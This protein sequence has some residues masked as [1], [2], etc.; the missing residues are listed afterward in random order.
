[1]STKNETKNETKNDKKDGLLGYLEVRLISLEHIPLPIKQIA[2]N[3]V[4]LGVNI[5]VGNTKRRTAS[6]VYIQNKETT[7]DF[8]CNVRIGVRLRDID[9]I[10]D[11]RVVLTLFCVPKNE[12]VEEQKDS[13]ENEQSKDNPAKYLVAAR[14]LPFMHLRE[15]GHRIKR[16]LVVHDK[17]HHINAYGDSDDDEDI[18]F[19]QHDAHAQQLP[20]LRLSLSWFPR[21]DLETLE[22]MLYAHIYAHEYRRY[23]L[24]EIQWQTGH[25]EGKPQSL[26]EAF[27]VK[28]KDE[29][30]K[31]VYNYVAESAKRFTGNLTFSRWNM[32]RLP[33]RCS[34]VHKDGYLKETR[35]GNVGSNIFKL[36]QR[37]TI[38]TVTDDMIN[39]ADRNNDGG[40]GYP[41]PKEEERIK[42]SPLAVTS[43]ILRALFVQVDANSDGELSKAEWLTAV[44]KNSRVRDLLDNPG[45]PKSLRQLLNP[46]KYRGALLLMDTNKDGLIS[47]EELLDFGLK[48]AK[49]QVQVAR[50]NARLRAEARSK[51]PQTPGI[52]VADQIGTLSPE[53]EAAN[54][55]K[56]LALKAKEAEDNSDDDDDEEIEDVEPAVFQ[57]LHDT[58]PQFTRYAEVFLTYGVAS[59]KRILKLTENEIKKM[60]VKNRD[61]KPLMKGVQRLKNEVLP[62][63]F[64]MNF[65]NRNLFCD[66]ASSKLFQDELQVLEH[67]ILLSAREALLK[68]RAEAQKFSEGKGDWG[69]NEDLLLTPIC[70]TPCI[71]L[72][73]ERHCHFDISASGL[74][75]P[76]GL[77]GNGFS[78]ASVKSVLR[79][80]SRIEN[81]TPSQI[82]T[83]V[84][85]SMDPTQLLWNRLKAPDSEDRRGRYTIEQI[86]QLLQTA[87]TCFR[88]A[89]LAAEKRN[90]GCNGKKLERSNVV[91]IH[92]SHWGCDEINAGNIKLTAICQ[93]IAAT[94]AGIHELRYHAVT[95]AQ[96][97]I[98]TEALEYCTRITQPKPPRKLSEA[99]AKVAEING[100]DQTVLNEMREGG[101]S[102][103]KIIREIYSLGLE[104]Q[105]VSK[106]TQWSAFGGGRR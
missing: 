32:L 33:M 12:D 14:V 30:K 28:F 49:Q 1:M 38:I 5:G 19:G 64:Y 15:N 78:R 98:V 87:Y 35:F 25:V 45:I 71:I 57:W 17:H 69:Y 88:G 26:V 106:A 68:L 48:L 63:H 27:P 2:W 79:A 16:T 23:L 80:C 77:W 67:P 90:Y 70:K 50:E 75:D 18:I 4:V 86:R 21:Y 43:A 72:G 66:G 65:A 29:R 97:D 94:T 42:Q 58:N 60:G 103:S 40:R 59:Y 101:T 36:P 56:A 89:V 44:T 102:T 54:I 41:K 105:H 95:P 81:P 55:A 73:A 96:M 74:H 20:L 84:P 83:A 24:R 92:T 8:D 99:E 76:N 82:I 47:M 53:E 100:I 61:I 22:P 85:L 9:D 34:H 62:F 93:I 13:N 6:R 104:W 3:D 10:D 91:I 51:K 52:G 11:A 7:A 31:A 46:R 37:G 39:Y